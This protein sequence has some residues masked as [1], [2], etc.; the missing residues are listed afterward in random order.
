MK[1]DN[2]P[3]IFWFRRDLRLSDHPGLAAAAATGRPV[4]SVFIR[5]EVVEAL[6]A[7][8]KW[9]LGLGLDAF[10]CALH[11]RGSRLI[12]RKGKAL[13][14]LRDLVD[15]T[16]AGSV[17]W[18][19]AYDPASIERDKRI[20]A[21]L[22]EDGIEVASSPGHLLFEPW[23]V[24]TKAGGPFKVYSPYWRA[25]R[26]QEVPEASTEPSRLIPPETWPRTEDPGDWA[27]G[28]EMRRGASVL[29]PH[30]QPG[31]A[32]ARAALDHFV[33]KNVNRYKDLRD[34]P[35]LA[36]TSGLSEY[37]SLGEIGPRTVWHAGMRAR[38]TGAPGA[39]AFLR[40][41]VWREF[42]YH[43]M[44]HSPSLLNGNW[45]PEWDDFPWNTDADHPNVAAWR[46]AGTGI[47]MVDAGLREMYVTGRMHNRT[48]MI[49]ASYL[50]KHLMTHW[51]IG[52]DWFAD[53]L[54]DWDPA[55]NAMG[56]QWVAGSGPDAA[57]YFRIFN[58]ETQAKKFDPDG[59]YRR[60][61][62][63]EGQDAPPETALSYFDAVPE[64]WGLRPD[65]E[66]P[67][68]VVGLDE[69]RRVALSAYE[70][71]RWR[72]TN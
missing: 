14:V 43:L 67:R 37:L 6:G 15:E 46:Q 40:Q 50:T 41:L 23:T 20:K 57:P 56:W 2:A 58:P 52:L 64:S 59:A 30:V 44:Y 33:D 51:K 21:A 18:T 1:A 62:I 66:Y 70:S 53:C 10:A 16:G 8:P 5:D 31:E 13:E 12:L 72:V 24:A 17:H 63:A 34:R 38:E 27:L 11:A 54:I 7:A 45:R 9:R 48:R 55:A 22:K 65:A 61:W 47:P 49:V 19:R 60:R 4:I 3:I 35:D 39:E 28:S 25:V 68:P 71:R 36:V 26:S 29:R 32:A 42:S 69:G